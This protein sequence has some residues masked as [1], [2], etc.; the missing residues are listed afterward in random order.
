M[1]APGPDGFPAGLFQR[2][3]G[4]L[5]EDI[6]RVV[7]QFFISGCMPEGVNNTTIV[8][9]PKV[10]N[11]HSMKDFRPISLCNVIYKIISKCL[12]NRLRPQLDGMISPTQS[13]FIPGRLISD[14]ALI[15]FECMHSLSTLKDSRGEYCAYKLDL[16]KA[17]D[18]VDWRFLESMLRAYGFAPVW[19]KWIMICVTSVKFSVR[20]N[21]QLLDLFQPSCGL[22]QGDPLSPYLFLF[23]AYGLSALFDSATILGNVSPVKICRSAPGISHLLFADD[24]M[25]F[26][27]AESSQSE[28][29]KKV[30]S[31]FSMATGLQINYHKSSMYPINVNGAFATSL[32]AQF[33]CQLGTMPFTYLGLPVGTT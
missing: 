23:V 14:N 19:V 24:T 6:V 16:A 22:R 21:G 12:V 7:Q 33:G 11:P 18:H 32:A 5:K 29:L 3:W 25:L 31:S 15:A 27:T 10:K 20:F 17:Y 26:L 2:N 13:A 28:A 8:R 9:I 1:K 4:F 30:L